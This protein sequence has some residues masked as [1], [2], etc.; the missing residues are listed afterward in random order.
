MEIEIEHA[1]GVTV[2]QPVG[3]LDAYTVP[4]FRERLTEAATK[5]N[6]IIDL[7][8]VPFMDSAGLGALAGGIRRTRDAGGDIVVSCNR[9]TL[10]RLL[11][12]TGFDKIVSVVGSVDEARLSL[13]SG[14]Q[15]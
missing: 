4:A 9:S 5:G 15:G 12:T 8:G 6:V 10:V 2:C 13:K 14:E 11:Q 7:S 1:D 3:D